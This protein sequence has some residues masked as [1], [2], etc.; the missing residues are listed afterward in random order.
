MHELLLRLLQAAVPT[1]M[2]LFSMAMELRRY[3]RNR[4][5]RKPS[6]NQPT[7]SM[8][9][10]PEKYLEVMQILRFRSMYLKRN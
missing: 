7:Q 3:Y 4:F 8:K 5:Q 6:K 2:P 9:N 10:M 1:L